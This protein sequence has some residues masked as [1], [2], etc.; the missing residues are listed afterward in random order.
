MTEFA[1]VGIRKGV[2]FPGLRLAASFALVA[3]LL[4]GCSSLPA[5]QD[6]A[7]VPLVRHLAD[8]VM[9]A[10]QVAL[11]KWDSGRPVHDP[12]REAQVIA[13]AVAAAPAYGL[14]AKDVE[15]LFTDQMEAS[16]QVQRFAP[17]WTGCRSRSWR[18]CGIWRL[19]ARPPTARP[20]WPMQWSVWRDERHSMMCIVRRLIVRSRGSASPIE[21]SGDPTVMR[22]VRG[23][24]RVMLPEG[25]DPHCGQQ[26]TAVKNRGQSRLSGAA[27][28][29]AGFNP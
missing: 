20:G 27:S 29:A 10:D 2:G 18:T 4:S 3:G 16:K 19:R 12:Q 8:R 9:T 22:R 28:A 24:R 23:V 13:N 15:D 25:R 7:F 14:A 26:K 17:G 11:S 1:F 6:D 21:R 5:A